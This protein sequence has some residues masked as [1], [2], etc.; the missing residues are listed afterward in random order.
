MAVPLAMPPVVSVTLPPAVPVLRRRLVPVPS[1][2]S[3]IAPLLLLPTVAPIAPA[4]VL[5]T[6]LLL[7]PVPIAPTPVF[8]SPLLLLPAPA[9]VFIPTVVLLPPP[10]APTPVLVPPLLLSPVPIT[11]SSVLVPPLMPALPSLV[12]LVP[13]A[14]P[15]LTLGY[16]LSRMPALR[17]GTVPGGVAHRAALETLNALLRTPAIPRHVPHAPALVARDLRVVSPVVMPPRVRPETQ[18]Q[19][20]ILSHLIMPRYRGSCQMLPF[21][22]HCPTPH[23]RPPTR[24]QS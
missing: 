11:P 20:L 14:I 10:V 6:P 4:P 21:H 5:V 1:L 18:G 16:E 7:L 12:P 19:G 24:H 3:L 13:V 17:V 15:I 22:N 23:Q 2:A 9:H 8:I